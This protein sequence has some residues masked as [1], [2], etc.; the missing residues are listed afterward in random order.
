MIWRA[1]KIQKPFGSKRYENLLDPNENLLDPKI[2]KP[3]GRYEIVLVGKRDSKKKK[4]D[5]PF[6]PYGMDDGD[7]GGRGIG[8]GRTTTC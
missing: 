1:R 4:D 6:K 2:R 8:I 7:D 3:L 5:F